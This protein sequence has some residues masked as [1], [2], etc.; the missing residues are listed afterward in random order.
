MDYD[1]TVNPSET[2]EFQHA[3]IRFNHYLAPSSLK[4]LGPAGN[5][6]G[7]PQSDCI[8]R[9]DILEKDTEDYFRGAL[10]QNIFEEF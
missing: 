2:V 1:E 6:S 8:G 7:I 9:V 10:S 5:F 4:L 3:G